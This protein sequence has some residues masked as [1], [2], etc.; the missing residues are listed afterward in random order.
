V[1]QSPLVEIGLPIALFIIMVGIGLTLTKADFR[2]EAEHPRAIVVG[3]IVQIIGMPLL[4]F[5]IA[6]LLNLDPLIALGLVVLA[7]CPG[8]TT[9]NLVTLL[10]RANVALSIVMTVVASIITIITLPV[11]ANLMLALQPIDVD[12]AIRVPL[13]R[14]IGLLVVII[15]VPISIGMV[16]RARRPEMAARAERGVSAFGALVLVLLIVAI[17]YDLREDL[18]DFLIQAGPAALLLNLGGMAVGL[19]LGVK[20]LSGRDARTCAVELGIKNGTLGILVG[21]TVIGGTVG[22]EIAVPAAVYSLVMYVTAPALIV[23]GRNRAL[24][25][26]D[27]EVKA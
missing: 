10:A 22:F 13:D 8:G 24:L 7:A 16:L 4:A 6:L 12:E 14:S 2:R 23:F 25:E 15:L 5:G 18:V 19:A 17:A 9:S 21:V 3:S 27:D 20:V 1:E 11:A 26:V